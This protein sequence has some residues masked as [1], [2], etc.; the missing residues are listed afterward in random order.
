MNAGLQK[1]KTL[2]E[3]HAAVLHH[4]QHNTTFAAECTDVD[5]DLSVEV[6]V[7]KVTAVLPVIRINSNEVSAP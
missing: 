4:S 7:V 1:G 5:V 3:K 2:P 6:G